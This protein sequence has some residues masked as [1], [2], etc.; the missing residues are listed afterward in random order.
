MKTSGKVVSSAVLLLTLMVLGCG[1]AKDPP[2]GDPAAP[3]TIDLGPA[4][5][6][7][8]GAGID[9]TQAGAGQEARNPGIQ[10]E[11][12]APEQQPTNTGSR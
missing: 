7:N 8:Q 3:P 12:Q 4:A 11:G 10:G 1:K 2:P 9:P 5:T 6:Q